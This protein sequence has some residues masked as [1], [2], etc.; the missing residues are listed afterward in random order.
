MKNKKAIST[1]K[2]G[3]NTI[4]VLTFSPHFHFGPYF[5]ILPYLIPKIK[6]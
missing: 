5:L 3:G 2:G 6:R 4:F 1:K